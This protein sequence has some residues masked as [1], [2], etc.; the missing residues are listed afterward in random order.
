MAQL[1]HHTFSWTGQFPPGAEHYWSFWPV[2]YEDVVYV[3]AIPV[4]QNTTELTVK[5]MRV[6]KNL[7][8]NT[9]NF[10]YTV[11]NTGPNN[12]LGYYVRYSVVKP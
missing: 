3:T 10:L 6:R 5:D 1:F 9:R 11:R 8:Q 7:G 12:I 2:S 4:A